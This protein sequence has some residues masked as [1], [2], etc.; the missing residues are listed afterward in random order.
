MDLLFKFKVWIF[1]KDVRVDLGSPEKVYHVGS[2]TIQFDETDAGLDIKADV[3][4]LHHTF[5]VP[6]G[7]TD[8][9]FHDGPASL[10]VILEGVEPTP[11]PAPA[12]AE[13][14]PNAPPAEPGNF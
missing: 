3:W 4:F 10:E 6:T 1:E 8:L 5:H 12:V 13:P 7:S 2:L 11:P 14:D 9:T